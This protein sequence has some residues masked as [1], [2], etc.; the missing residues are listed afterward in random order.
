VAEIRTTIWLN[1]RK[2]I[3]PMEQGNAGSRIILKRIS[4]EEEGE[5]GLSLAGSAWGPAEE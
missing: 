4:S 2:K 3:N 5:G 1:N